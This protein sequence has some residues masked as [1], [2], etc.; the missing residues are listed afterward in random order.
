[1]P[2]KGSRRPKQAKNRARRIRVHT[3]GQTERDYLQIWNRQNNSVQ[4]S[5]GSYGDSP[6]NLVKEATMDQTRKSQSGDDDY[7]EVWC[8]FDVNQHS[9]LDKAK[10]L[11]RKNGIK[12]VI[13]NPCFELWLV[14]HC[15]DRT[16]YINSKVIQKRA[17]QLSIVAGKRVP[18]SSTPTILKNY[19]KAKERAKDLDERHKCN[20]NR[21]G[22]NPSSSVW[23]LV[24]RIKPDRDTTS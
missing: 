3:D 1:M 18:K 12:T 21:E 8:V 9:D 10:E 11:A 17:E 23:R 20:E 2:P 6:L 14:L 24:D 22:S 4:L 5:L 15:E 16:G 13:S 19:E 7:N